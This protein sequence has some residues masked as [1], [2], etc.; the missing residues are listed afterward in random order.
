[1]AVSYGRTPRLVDACPRRTTYGVCYWTTKINGDALRA[2]LF[3]ALFDVRTPRLV[4]ARAPSA[5]GVR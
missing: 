5:Y 1:M 3:V 2:A 4:D